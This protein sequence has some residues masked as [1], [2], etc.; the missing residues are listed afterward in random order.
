MKISYKKLRLFAVIYAIIPVITFYIGWFATIAALIFIP[1]TLVGF[2]LFL[3]YKDKNE[4]TDIIISR[5]QLIIIAVIS[6]LWCFLAG[7]GAFIHQS[8]DNIIRNAIFRDMIRLPWPVIYNDDQLLSY[9]IAHWMVPAA[10]GK[11]IMLLTGSVNAGLMAG[12]IALLIWSS[13]GI[14]IALLLLSVITAHA[15][16]ARAILASLIFIFFSG[17]DIIGTV[18]YNTNTSHLEWWAKF[19]QFSSFSTCLFWVYNQFIVSL[20]ITLCIIHEKS[21]INFAFLGILAFPYGPFPFVGIVILCVIKAVIIIIDKIKAKKLSE[22]LREIFTPQNILMLAAIGLPYALYYISNPIVSNEV[23]VG[24]GKH[25]ETG[26]RFHSQLSEYI[27]AG[28]T[29]DSVLFLIKYLLF[30]AL[31]VGV[32]LT[33]IFIYQKKN[34]CLNKEFILSSSTLLLIPLFQI[35]M[36][37]DF[38]MRVSIPALI[39]IAVEF[40]KMLVTELPSDT[41]VIIFI[42]SLIKKPLLVAALLVFIIGSYTVMIEFNREINDTIRYGAESETDTEYLFSLNDYDFKANFASPNYRYSLFYKYLLRK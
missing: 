29:T 39:F 4:Y 31:E 27:S 13:T 32:F 38:S 16:K 33:I 26:F 6:L 12:R 20:I 19:A 34:K 18:L 9:Y 7:Q 1:L 15:G 36:G 8:E 11:G 3:R 10:F 17:L 14:F 22:G 2:V 37:Y 28:N 35:G 42:R 40:I 24:G 5:K 25:I 21:T 23:S 30:I 41:D